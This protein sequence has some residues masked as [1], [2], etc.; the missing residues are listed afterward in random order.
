M[1]VLAI[2]LLKLKF[3]GSLLAVMDSI[4]P[5]QGVTPQPEAKVSR[6]LELNNAIQFFIYWRMNFYY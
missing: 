4:G 1:L 5:W 6:F 3:A 2:P